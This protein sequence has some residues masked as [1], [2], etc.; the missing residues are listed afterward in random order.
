MTFQT[1]DALVKTEFSLMLRSSVARSQVSEERNSVSQ[2]GNL[3]GT[4]I[5]G[6]NVNLPRCYND[7][8][9]NGCGVVFKLDPNGTETVI[10]AFTGGTDGGGPNSD[11]IRD[12]AGNLYGT[13]LWGGTGK[14]VIYAQNFPGCGVVFKITP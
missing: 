1:D 14:C 5:V 2:K 4:T 9:G 12:A 13:T 8:S 11:L 3:Y 6:G 7:F 10:Y